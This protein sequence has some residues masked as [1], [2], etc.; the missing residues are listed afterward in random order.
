MVSALKELHPNVGAT[1][2]SKLAALATL[3]EKATIFLKV[4]VEKP[5]SKGRFAQELAGILLECNLRASAVPDY[6]RNALGHLGV[7]SEPLN[8]G[9]A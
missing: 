9:Q 7:L 8:D 5:V 6:I 3:E 2:E 4:F 1:L